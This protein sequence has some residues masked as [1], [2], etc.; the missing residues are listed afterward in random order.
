VDLSTIDVPGTQLALAPAAVEEML[1][2]FRRVL[3]SERLI[4][5]DETRAFEEACAAEIGTRHAVGVSSGT[6][7]LEIIL[8]ALGVSGRSVLVPANTFYATAVAVI[9]AGGEPVLVDVGD[10]LLVH[11]DMLAAAWRDDT[12]SAMVVEIGGMIPPDMA[13]I[14]QVVADRGG[15]V[16]EDAAQALGSTCDLGAAGGLGRAGS[17]SF[18]PTKIVTA[19]EGGMVSTDDDEIARLA[20]VLRDQGKVSFGENMHVAEGYSWRLSELHAVVGAVHLRWLAD[21]IARMRE[22]A[23][24]YDVELAN[25][26][27]RAVPEP[28]EHTWNRYKYVAILPEGVPR[29]VVQELLAQRGIGLSGSVF[30]QP[31]NLQPVFQDRFGNIRMPVA[32]SVCERHVCLP[33]SPNMS[34]GDAKRVAAEIIDVVGRAT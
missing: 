24:I 7:G 5:G 18:Y 9:R 26:P 14:R 8:R 1:A 20:L 23:A 27:L 2:G 3:D 25:S 15:F 33:I 29:G 31:L 28:E 19:V 21:T 4:L 17:T 12:C 13:A 34:A 22:I 32:E 30:A 16:V 10:D 11:A 6:A